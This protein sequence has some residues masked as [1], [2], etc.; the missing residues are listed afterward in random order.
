MSLFGRRCSKAVALA[1]VGATAPAFGQPLDVYVRFEDAQRDAAA[2]LGAELRSEGHQLRFVS[3]AVAPCARRAGGAAR[4]AGLAGEL[5][6]EEP[7]LP[8]ASIE[9]ALDQ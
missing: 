8:L 2:R 4:R 9:I 7:A 6:P 5:P 1:I 3:H